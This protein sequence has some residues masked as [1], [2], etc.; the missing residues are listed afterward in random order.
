MRA[1]LSISIS[2]IENNYLYLQSVCKSAQCAAV[3]KADAYGLGIIQVAPAL[4]N[5]GARHFFVAL[6]EEGI[7]LR[8]VVKDDAVIYVL[9]GLMPREAKD[10]LAYNLCPV[11]NNPASIDE[12]ISATEKASCAIQVDTG[13]NRLGL[14]WTEWENLD[15]SALD[16]QLLLS[17]LACADT[18]EH[19]MNATQRQRFDEFLSLYPHTKFPQTKNSQVQASLAASDGIFCG[20]EFHFDMVRPGAALYG[21]NPI[22]NRQNPMQQVITLQAPVLAIRDVDQDG[23]VGYAASRSVTNGQKLAAIGIGYADGFFRSLSNQGQMYFND[24]ALPVMGRVSM[25]I[26]MVDISAL[27]ENMLN[28][29]DYVDIINDRQSA[30]YLGHQSGTIGYEV[31]TSLGARFTRYYR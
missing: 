28:S 12:W 25:D 31:L 3:V 6:M 29:G 7:A 23:S 17:H 21:I 30:D 4:Y 10:M 5:A 27:P 19:V 24:Y 16:L 13:L 1:R 15:K 9:N 14:S 26:V 18:P 2:A 8:S 11:L 20:E 22:P